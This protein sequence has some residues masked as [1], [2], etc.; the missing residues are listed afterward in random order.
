MHKIAK[1]A[2]NSA[3]LRQL[4]KT[5]VKILFLDSDL[6]DPQSRK[7]LETEVKQC[8]GPHRVKICKTSQ[9]EFA[10]GVLRPPQMTDE[11]L[12]KISLLL[13]SGSVSDSLEKT[14]MSSY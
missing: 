8:F 4:L 9:P 2:E 6:K 10:A 11:I 14:Q 13:K 5:Q 1:E 7:D 12:R 3:L